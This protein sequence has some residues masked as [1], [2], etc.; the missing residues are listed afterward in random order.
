MPRLLYVASAAIYPSDAPLPTP[1]TALG[2]GAP[3]PSMAGYARA[4]I[5][6]IGL[7]E[8][9]AGAG[10]AYSAAAPCN[11]YGPGDRFEG[12]RSTVLAGL[13]ARA[14]EAQATGAADLVI[15]GTGAATREFLHADDAAAALL[16]LLARWEGGGL[17][18]VGSGEEVAVAEVARLAA[19]AAGFEG[20][21]VFDPSKPEG[22]PRK[23]LDVTR[24]RELGWEPRVRLAYGIAGLVADYR[25]RFSPA[26]PAGSRAGL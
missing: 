4:K 13:T 3:D 11:L 19:R 17:V 5:A 20:H 9:W 10:L 26:S 22:A 6:G 16:L 8:A 7:C 12:G 2:T 15:W 1:E 25:S 23:R 14:V 18:N 24:L 21:L